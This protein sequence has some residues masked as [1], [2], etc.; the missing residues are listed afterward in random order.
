MLILWCGSDAEAVRKVIAPVVS[1]HTV[2]HQV[3][4]V[5]GEY[6]V[7][8]AGDVVVAFGTKALTVLQSMKAVPKNRTVGSL[9]ET[10]LHVLGSQ[11]LVTYD[12]GITFRDYA[13]LPEIQWD[14]ALAIRLHNTG[15]TAPKFGAYR[16]VDDF[17]ELVERIEEKYEDTGKPVEVACDLETVG[18][19]EWNPDAWIVSLF[20]TV[21]KGKSDGMYFKQGETLL[22]SEVPWEVGVW[23][24]VQWLLTSDKVSI[25]GANFKYD[26]RWISKKWGIHCTNQKFDTVLVGSLLDENRSNSL[27]L[28]AKIYTDMGGYEDGMEK[29]DFERMDLVPKEKIR[30]YAGGDTD[31]TLRIAS[32]MKTELLRDTRLT[33]L[34]VKLVQP[35]AKVFE[36]METKGICIDR[37]YFAELEHELI[38]EVAR[39]EH[40]MLALVPNKIKIKYSDDLKITKPALLKEF[41][42]TP[43]GLNL[44]PQMLT[45]KTQEPSTAID[46]LMMFMDDPVAA[47]FIS[48]F[49]E[50]GSTTKTLSTY[51]VG[52]LKHVRSD[53]RFH[54]TFMLHRGDYGNDSDDSGTVTGR[55][56]A[57][58]P[59]VQTIPKHTRWTKKLRRGYIAPPGYA[60]LEV[61][62]SQGELKITAC[63]AEEPTMLAA[64]RSG[65]DLHTLTAIKLNSLT[66][67]QFNALPKAQQKELRSGGKAGNFGLIYGMGANG[68]KDYAWYSYGVKLED[69]EA[70]G[71]REAFFEMYNRLPE[72]HVEGRAFAHQHG[73]VRSPLGRIRHLPL[74]NTKDR[75]IV[76]K[77]ERQ[78]V[79]SPVQSCLSD[80]MQYAM[81]LIDRQ[82]GHEDIHMFLMTHDSL[83]LYVPEDDAVEWANRITD[84]MGNLPL[85]KEFHW[86]HQLQFTA[87]ASVSEVT[88]GVHSL[89]NMLEL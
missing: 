45:A 24:Q 46:H 58:D 23:E 10:P 31:V 41:L 32:T 42:F 73:Y 40:S 60:I 70:V 56:S 81:V 82:Y 54:P 33:N 16:W 61:D 50:Y 30:L 78:A 28:H 84:L 20:F 22:P 26:S 77:Q 85:K 72:W 79:N 75:E 63:L 15:T 21:D 1:R 88:D 66:M 27:K 17:N 51:V 7:H 34:Y 8:S 59:A 19:D 49:K 13:R 83:S 55:T 47:N 3:V 57:K 5:G 76:S 62:F 6:P 89:A 68:Y 11:C 18:L 69:Y 29:K 12:P 35:A 86:D 53:G 38:S 39:L 65:A 71:Q 87:D 9:R 74:I 67:E 14:I 2:E 4:K 36:K 48:L 43:R 52:F 44:K 37:P 80:M 25:R 64:Y